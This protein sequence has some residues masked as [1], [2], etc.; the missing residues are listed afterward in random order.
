MGELDLRER[1]RTHLSGGGPEERRWGEWRRGGTQGIPEIKGTQLS[2][3]A[4][5]A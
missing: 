2:P 4:Q 3:Q 5:E 1:R